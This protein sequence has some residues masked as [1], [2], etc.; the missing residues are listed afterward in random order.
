MRRL[1]ILFLFATASACSVTTSFD[2]LVGGADAASA[3]D[4]APPVAEAGEVDAAATDADRGDAAGPFDDGSAVDAVASDAGATDGDAAQAPPPTY[5]Q[6][7][8]GLTGS[9]PLRLQLAP[10]QAGNAIIVAAI[11]D[12]S[13]NVVTVVDDSPAGTGYVSVNQRAQYGT[14]S[15]TEIW[16]ARNIGAGATHVTITTAGGGGIEG[17]AVEFSGLNVTAPFDLGATIS[18]QPDTSPIVAP[19]VRPSSPRALVVSVAVTANAITGI[20][21]DNPFIALPIV[22]GDDAAFFVTTTTGSYGASWTSSPG[23][24]C[25]S[26]AAFK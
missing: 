8:Q 20:Q 25:A 10:T 2:G 24:W 22:N 11:T 5:V 17:W 13:D 14:A 3:G 15:A 26:T 7:A 1:P 4:S 9:S 23:G 16:V 18:N 12:A 21:T 19:P 6:S